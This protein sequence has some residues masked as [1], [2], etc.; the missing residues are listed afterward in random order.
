MLRGLL[1]PSA[2]HFHGYQADRTQGH[3]DREHG[4]LYLVHPNLLVPRARAMLWL[5]GS[6][7]YLS[8]PGKYGQKSHFSLN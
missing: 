3:H 2:T 8:R 4:E 6:S 7:F 5:C 1:L